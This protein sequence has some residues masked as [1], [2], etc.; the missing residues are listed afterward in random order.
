MSTIIQYFEEHSLPLYFFGIGIKTDL[1]Q[2]SHCWVFQICW[3]I[4]YNTVTDF[5]FGFKTDL[6]FKNA[7]LEL[8]HLH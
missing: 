3:C 8:L 2:S 7:Q 4:E 1:F 6:G 5:D